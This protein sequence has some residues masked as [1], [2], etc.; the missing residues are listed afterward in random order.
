MVSPSPGRGVV[1][2]G[3]SR[4]SPCQELP[5]PGTAHIQGPGEEGRRKPH[6]CL[7]SGQPC[8]P[9]TPPALPWDRPRPGRGWHHSHCAPGL[10]PC[11]PCPITSAEPR[12][13]PCCG[14]KW[15]HT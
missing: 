7:N 10:A 13:L 2:A 14:D 12:A 3:R 4:L 6:P 15:P 1:A 11:R 9:S 8:R 5:P